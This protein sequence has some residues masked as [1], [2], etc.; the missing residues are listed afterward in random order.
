V[1]ATGQYSALGEVGSLLDPATE[2]HP[3]LI[4]PSVYLRD[5]VGAIL[6]M[7][8]RVRDCLRPP[9][10]LR[11]AQQARDRVVRRQRFER[12]AETLQIRRR[13][14]DFEQAAVLLH[15][16][17]SSPAV[18]CVDHQAHRAARSQ[19]VAEGAKTVVRVGQVMQHSGTNR[20]IERP[21][22]LPD[23]LN[24]DLMQMEIL[25]IVLIPKPGERDSG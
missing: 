25:Q 11:A 22:N 17:D 6:G 20:Q 10:I 2:G 12:V 14:A 18:A 13:R 23:A 1:R 24:R 15:H 21:T 9:K 19:D 3:A 5:G 4:E 8:E 16:I 7:K